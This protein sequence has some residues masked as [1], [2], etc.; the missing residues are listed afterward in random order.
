MAAPDSVVKSRG[1]LSVQL[2]AVVIDH[3]A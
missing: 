3:A 2:T 1:L